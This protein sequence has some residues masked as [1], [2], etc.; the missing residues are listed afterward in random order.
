MNGKIVSRILRGLSLSLGLLALAACSSEKTANGE[1]AATDA[2]PAASVGEHSGVL[3]TAQGAYQFTPTS[4]L[5]N[6]EDG[7]YDIEIQGPGQTPDGEKFYFELSSTGNEMS[8]QLGVDA[9]FQSPERR[10]VAGQYV[11]EAFTLDVSDKS[12]SIPKLVLNNERG[13][14]VDDNASLQIDCQG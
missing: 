14:R 2:A 8:V 1:A 12:L 13:E 4:C 5:F 9:P 10:L 11:S 6:K 7:V 3:Q